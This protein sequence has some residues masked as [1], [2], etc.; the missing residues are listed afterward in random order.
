MDKIAR[1]S[2]IKNEIT[3]NYKQYGRVKAGKLYHLLA[4]N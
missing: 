4:A 2:L 1:P 3:E